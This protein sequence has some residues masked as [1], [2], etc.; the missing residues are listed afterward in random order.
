MSLRV[1]MIAPTPFFGDRGCHVRILEEIRALQKAGAR[2]LLLTYPAGK[3]VADVE[4]R[5]LDSLK[6]LCKEKVG[7]QWEKLI[8]DA[9][10]TAKSLGWALSF[11]PDIIHGHLHEGC[12]IGSVAG[13]LL[14]VPVVFD[15]QGSLSGEMSHH[16]FVRAGSLP[17]AVFNRLERL[18]NELPS[19][20]LASSEAMKRVEAGRRPGRWLVVSDAVDTGRF[21]TMQ[22]D[23]GLARRLGLPSGATVCAFLG[24]LNA[25]Q[26]VDLLLESI[27][28]VKSAGDRTLHFLIMGYPGVEH[29]AGL[30]R[31][32]GISE[33]VTFTGRIPY[34]E[35]S[36]Y[37]NLADFA[38]APKLAA[39]ESNGK[40]INYMAC[41]L[42]TVALDTAVNRELLGPAGYYVPWKG[43][44]GQAAESLGEALLDMARDPEKR[45]RLAA[46]GRE[47][48]EERFG[49]ERMSRNLLEAYDT[50]IGGRGEWS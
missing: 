7:P 41:G 30:A 32:L 33:R 47:R 15:Y 24:L 21:R 35:A 42:A 36:R 27:A 29:Y 25:Y 50:V 1:L 3:D 38:V 4:I 39:T 10:L 18:L 31:E 43:R 46:L 9:G 44:L 14:R 28:R 26:G 2:I 12:L 19:A 5:R 16:G 49:L 23:A 48:V 20:V 6:F 8:L 40:I 45:R 13:G 17:F 11:K 22:R 37:L 34:E